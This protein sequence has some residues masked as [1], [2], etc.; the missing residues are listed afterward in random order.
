MTSMKGNWTALLAGRSVKLGSLFPS[1]RPLS[2]GIEPKDIPVFNDARRRLTSIHKT[3]LT[4][5]EE[6]GIETLFAAVGLATWNVESGTPPNA[7]V[8]LLPLHV[9]ATGAAARDFTLKVEG[10]AHLNPVL[11]HILR[12]DH[13]LETEDD[14]ADVAEDPPS[15]YGRL[16][17]PSRPTAGL[18]AGAPRSGNRTARCRGDI[19]VL[20][21]AAG[22]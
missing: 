19:L 10:D 13:D 18:L 4:N 3:A 2:L 6:K 7:P 11:T 14:E 17:G 8:V 1:Q 5:S 21:N 15:S 12:A 9:E 22:Q 16:Y 20:D